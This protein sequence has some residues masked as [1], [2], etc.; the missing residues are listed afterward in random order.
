M[1]AVATTATVATIAVDDV[2]AGVDVVVVVVV[3]VDPDEPDP[4]P[5]ALLEPGLVAVVHAAGAVPRMFATAACVGASYRPVAD[6]ITGVS[7]F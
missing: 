1:A 4:V 7:P 2:D 5:P 6:G 3:V